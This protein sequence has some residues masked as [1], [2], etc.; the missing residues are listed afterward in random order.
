[1]KEIREF[2]TVFNRTFS[3]HVCYY[4]SGPS[5]IHSKKHTK[6]SFLLQLS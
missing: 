3:C 5:T 1:L 2:H 6:P 4:I